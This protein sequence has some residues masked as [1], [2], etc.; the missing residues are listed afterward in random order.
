MTVPFPRAPGLAN[1]A[2]RFAHRGSTKPRPDPNR[3]SAGR[4][5][6]LGSGACGLHSRNS[7]VVSA[8]RGY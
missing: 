6:S 1:A 2:R 3:P 4:G 7:C 8:G 5:S